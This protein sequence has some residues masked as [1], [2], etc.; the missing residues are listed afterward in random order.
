MRGREKT[1]LFYLDEDA[2]QYWQLC[3]RPKTGKLGCF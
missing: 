1:E 2:F 3:P